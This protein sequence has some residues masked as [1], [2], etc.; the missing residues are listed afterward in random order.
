M[1]SVSL[2]HSHNQST[3]STSVL[4][5][6]EYSS[7]TLTGQLLDTRIDR[8]EVAIRN[9]GLEFWDGVALT[10]GYA[11]VTADIQ[12]TSWFYDV[13]PTL[14]VGTYFVSVIGFDGPKAFH[15]FTHFTFDHFAERPTSSIVQATGTSVSGSSSDDESVARLDLAIRTAGPNPLYWDGQQLVNSYQLQSTVPAGNGDWTFELNPT[16]PDGDYIATSSAVDTSGLRQS[17]P[18]FHKAFT[19]DSRLSGNQCGSDGEDGEGCA[20]YVGPEPLVSGELQD[21]RIVFTAGDS[22]VAAGGGISI[23]FHHASSWWLQTNDPTSRHYIST[24]GPLDLTWTQAMPMGMFERDH[25][26]YNADFKF[27][28]LLIARATEDIAPGATIEFHLGAGPGQLRTQNFADH[29]HQFRVATDVDGD[30]EFRGIAQSPVVTIVASDPVSVSAVIPSQ[31]KVGQSFEAVLRVEDEFYNRVETYSGLFNLVDENGVTVVQNVAIQSGI[32]KT[33]VSIST[34]GPHRLRIV[35]AT[36]NLTGRSNPV[37][38]FNTLPARRLYW[39][40]LHGHTGESDGLGLDA[41]EYFDFG[42][43]VAAL[44]FIALTDHGIPNWPA[45]KEAVRKY[46]KPGDCVTIL[47]TE[48]NSR[49]NPRDHNNLYYRRDDATPLPAWPD[50]YVDYLADLWEHYNQHH[51]NGQAMTGPHHSAYERGFAGDDNYP[52]NAWDDRS[53]RFFEVYSSHGTSEYRNNPR[54]LATWSLDV[55]KY[56]QG[57]LDMGHKFAVIAASDNHDSKPG[58]SAWGTYPGGLA[59]VWANS[60]DRDSV[61]DAIWNYQTYGTS[62]DR[63]YVDFSVDDAPMGSTINGDGVDNIKLYV[64]GK[65]DNLTVDLISNGGAVLQSWSTTTGVVNVTSVQA[66]GGYYYAR[67]TQENGER[68]WSTPVWVTQ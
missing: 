56:M 64:I 5:V 63:I 29:D 30:G 39:G 23:G 19:V 62:A 42:C 6:D 4:T 25:T 27:H 8:V 34:P 21:W 58:R 65:E 66:D 54:P 43:N 67:V 60:L 1:F 2:S 52:F 40:E 31:A 9:V 68:A 38:V 51:S 15:P 10:S 59:A 16:L 20:V 57:G 28:R 32:G 14:P 44:D 12:G 61:F 50:T 33:Q 26:V 41:D 49:F 18:F 22:G 45:N 48:Q 24:D 46:H 36:D 37:R 11:R 53:A 35:S 13:N 55:S 7:N 47:A 3:A 17:R